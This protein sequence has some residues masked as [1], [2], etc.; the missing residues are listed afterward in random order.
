[1]TITVGTNTWITVANADTYLALSVR[2]AAWADID[3]ALKE[4]AL[5][6]AWRI[7]D[8]MNWNEETEVLI[9]ADTPPQDLIDAQCEL[10][11]DLSQNPDSE[12]QST[13]GSNVKKVQGGPA[14]VEYFRP[15]TGGRQSILVLDLIR[16]YLSSTSSY[17][18]AIGGDPDCPGAS[19][20]HAGRFDVK[21]L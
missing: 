3:T 7:L 20:F 4:R 9:A 1:M 16:G 11:F 14:S 5:V 10:A 13:G 6:S 17:G 18:E 2:A 21:N 12:T 15:T 8:R 19:H